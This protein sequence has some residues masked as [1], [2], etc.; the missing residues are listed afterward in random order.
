MKIVYAITGANG[1]LGSF[2]TAYLRK[3]GH[4]VYELVRSESK[5]KNQN[6]YQYFDLQKS[7]KISSLIG[8]HVLIHAAFFFDVSN[9]KK[10]KDINT[11]GTVA[12][13]SQAKKDGVN[14]NIFIST[15]SAYANAKSLYGK[16]KYQLEQMLLKKGVTIIRPGLIFC[17]SLHGIVASINN[18]IKKFPVIP[19][20]GFGNQIIYPCHLEDLTKLIYQI[21]LNQ[22]FIKDPVAAA[23]EN[24]ITFKKLVQHLENGNRKK[25]LSLPLPF[26]IIYFILKI[27][28]LIKLPIGLRSDSLLGLQYTNPIID[29]IECKKLGGNFRAFG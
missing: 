19:V 15:L 18:F 25:V 20:I 26:F 4:I 7:E 10:Y 13:F 21:S 24:A 23:S 14:Y 8:V 27:A 28:E 17:D 11:K 6:Y 12:L 16:I 22:P 9:P 5:A 29:F 2:L 1:Q 3:Q